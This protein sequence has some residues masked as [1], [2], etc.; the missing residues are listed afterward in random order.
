MFVE[1]SGNVGDTPVLS[2][3]NGH[4]VE[5][6]TLCRKA[7]HFLGQLLQ[8][9]FRVRPLLGILQKGHLYESLLLLLGTTLPH[10]AVCLFQLGARHALFLLIASVQCLAGRREKLVVEADDA[11]LTSPVR[12]ERTFLDAETPVIAQSRQNFPVAASPAV[13]AL[14]DVAHDEA[15]FLLCQAFLQQQMEVLP[16]HA[17][18]ILKLVNHYRIDGGTD[19]LVDKRGVSLPD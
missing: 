11:C 2:H 7:F 18:G 14:L 10:I 19:F 12:V 13:D 1:V 3:Q 17:R 9:R 16:L 5:A 6:D 15:A 4:L 8:G